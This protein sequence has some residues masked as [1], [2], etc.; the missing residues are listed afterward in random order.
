MLSLRK[1][2]RGDTVGV[3]GRVG[4]Y[5]H[6][7]GTCNHIDIRLS[8]YETLSRSDIN[9][10]RSRN[11]VD[12]S[13]ALRAVSERRYSL[14]SAH[15][16]YLIYACDI[17]RYEYLVFNPA[18]G[19]DHDYLAYPRYLGGSRVH[20]HGG[21]IA[22]CTAGDIYAYFCKRSYLLP[23]YYAVLAA[24]LEA[25]AKLTGMKCRYIGMRLAQYIYHPF[26]A[27]RVSVCY[28]LL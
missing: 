18:C 10:A 28:L 26:I 20:E 13:Y 19:C 17:R 7:A 1:H 27:A 15:L 16:I 14:S 6:L 11:L 2:V 24:H 25:A 4:D 12:G 9:I 21:W 23:Q 5:Q 8:E 22:G 3:G